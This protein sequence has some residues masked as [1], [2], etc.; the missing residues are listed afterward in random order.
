MLQW[1]TKNF[2]GEISAPKKYIDTI[3][4]TKKNNLLGRFIQFDCFLSS[5]DEKPSLIRAI[6]VSVT[7]SSLCISVKIN[8]CFVRSTENYTC[9]E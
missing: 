2:G 1:E 8:Y 5:S 3:K 9:Y 7:T 4:E 6:Y